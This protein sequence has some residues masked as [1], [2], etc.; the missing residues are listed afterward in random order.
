MERKTHI[1]TIISEGIDLSN[2]DDM[3]QYVAQPLRTD[4]VQFFEGRIVVV[5]E[6]T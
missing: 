4:E 5:E 2:C 1:L 3:R 6:N